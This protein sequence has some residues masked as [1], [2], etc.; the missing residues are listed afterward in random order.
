VADLVVARL[1][2]GTTPWLTRVQAAEYLAIPAS[3][4]EKDKRVPCHRWSGRVLYHRD[5]LDDFVR[6]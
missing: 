4:L 3:R 6:T 1:D 2:A 5:E